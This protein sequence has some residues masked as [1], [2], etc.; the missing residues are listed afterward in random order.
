[1][2]DIDASAVLDQHLG[3]RRLS[4]RGQPSGGN[5]TSERCAGADRRQPRS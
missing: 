1:M 3:E 2:T 5:L 4:G